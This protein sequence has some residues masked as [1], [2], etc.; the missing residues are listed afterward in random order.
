MPTTLLWIA[1]AASTA[2]LFAIASPI[3]LSGKASFHGQDGDTG[4]S[5]LFYFL[6]PWIFRVEYSPEGTRFF[7]L[8]FRR[9]KRAAA[10]NADSGA[11]DAFKTSGNVAEDA[12]GGNAAHTDAVKA[13]DAG[14]DTGNGGNGIG[15]NG[16]GSAPSAGGK[17]RPLS[18]KFKSKINAI[19][20]NRAYRVASDKPLRGKLWRW[21]KRSLRR[22]LRAASIEKLK[23]HAKI[24]LRDP[25]ALG[26]A[27]G[28]F[29]AAKRALA[30]RNRSIDL[31]MEP[32]FNENRFDIDSEFAV[33]TTLSTILWQLMAIAATF[34]YRRFFKVW[35]M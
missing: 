4:F 5:A 2:L 29:S 31:S 10:V 18:A 22:A 3:R 30:P 26:K 21:L 6:H 24:G 13:D 27:Y 12:A 34:P 23:V 14:A 1:L 16:G 35:S 19:K 17:K 9:K 15:G 11:A 20:R 8:G 25:A 32:I 7:I 33:K 28:Y